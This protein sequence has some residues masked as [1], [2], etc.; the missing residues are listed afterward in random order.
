MGH[1][2]QCRGSMKVIALLGEA[3]E[4]HRRNRKVQPS[5]KAIRKLGEGVGDWT[6]ILTVRSKRV[7]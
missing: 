6:V 4:G 7:E 1:S 5:W 3:Q 2:Q